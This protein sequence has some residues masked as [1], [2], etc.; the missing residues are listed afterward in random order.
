M[1]LVTLT[2]NGVS[3][4]V[5]Q[6]STVLQACEEVGN[7]VPRFCYHARLL[8]AGNCRMCLVEV[9]G[10]PKPVV[11]CAMPAGEGMVVLTES[12]MVSKAREA[13]ME[14]LLLNHPRDCPICDQGGECDLQDQAMTYGSDRSRNQ[15]MKRSVADKERN[16]LIAAIMTR[17]I[18]CTRCIR[19][20][21]EVAGVGELGTSTRGRDVEVGS[22]VKAL[23]ESVFSGNVVDLCPV[24]ALTEK[25]YQFESRAW[26]E[27]ELDS[28]DPT[29]GLYSWV[30]RK[31]SLT[32]RVRAVPRDCEP[33][34]GEWLTD[35]GRF[36]WDGFQANRS[37]GLLESY[38]P[39][40]PAG[41][42]D[43]SDSAVIV[44]QSTGE[45]ERAASALSQ[46][47]SSESLPAYSEST[48]VNSTVP[49]EYSMA[50]FAELEESDLVILLGVDP[51]FE[52]AML[53]VELRK[54]VLLG[55][56]LKS[57]V[58][59]VQI[60][61][62]KLNSSYGTE[63]T[64]TLPEVLSGNSS[65]SGLV[66]QAA[67]PTVLVGKDF[68]ESNSQDV[69]DLLGSFTRVSVG[70]LLPNAVG[71][72]EDGRTRQQPTSMGGLY[73]HTWGTTT[74]THRN[75][76]HIPMMDLE[77]DQYYGGLPHSAEQATVVRNLFNVPVNLGHGKPINQQLGDTSHIMT[78]SN[79]V[80]NSWMATSRITIIKTNSSSQVRS[81]G[82][83]RGEYDYWTF[84][85][86]MAA[87]S[88]LMSDM[89]FGRTAGKDGVDLPGSKLNDSI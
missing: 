71:E 40:Y 57:N 15:T 21:T 72:L 38:G 62:E 11:S 56:R 63:N 84:G 89:S 31:G 69:C 86:D 70:T 75:T 68:L 43:G 5:P 10:A 39:S 66:A 45:L 48:P 74:G 82:P 50:P 54:M 73:V 18:H 60:S 34:N 30:R 22:Y 32:S 16:P 79:A 67:L 7:E 77:S 13:V 24:G 55:N 19:F 42:V 2:V 26:E 23:S 59:V 3:V 29:D 35:K 52:M 9:A 83:S 33:L 12:P 80:D 41:S 44:S 58:S 53:D 88:A 65:I 8:V 1:G 20:S 47:L 51:T 14:R 27:V 6:G 17:C 46:S 81:K 85:S 37:L 36:A 64:A 25:P 78:G 28:Y 49:S 4:E 76:V 61:D 87:H